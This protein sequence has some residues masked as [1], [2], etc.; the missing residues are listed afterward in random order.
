MLIVLEM[1]GI[2][3]ALGMQKH[4]EILV[5]VV[6]LATLIKFGAIANVVDFSR[7]F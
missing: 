3:K 4:F 2:I 5:V 6:R 7:T 1:L